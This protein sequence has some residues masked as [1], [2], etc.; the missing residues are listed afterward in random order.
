MLLNVHIISSKKIHALGNSSHS[1]SFDKLV[2]IFFFSDNE[3][4][5]IVRVPWL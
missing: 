1:T 4:L 5:V 3:D 2:D